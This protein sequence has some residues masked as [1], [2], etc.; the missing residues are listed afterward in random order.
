[1]QDLRG[2]NCIVPKYVVTALRSINIFRK[3]E[4]AALHSGLSKYLTAQ[5]TRSDSKNRITLGQTVENPQG[6]WKFPPIPPSSS[7]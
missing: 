6:V 4:H 7:I 3:L 1:M 2:T 5:D